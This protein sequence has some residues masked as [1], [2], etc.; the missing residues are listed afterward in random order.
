MAARGLLG[1]MTTFDQTTDAT[2]RRIAGALAFVVG[3]LQYA[4]LEGVAA[5]AWRSPPYDYVSN[6]ISD[7]GVADPQTYGGRVVDSPLAW[8]MNTG[9]VLEG[10]FFAVAAVLLSIA[11]SG[12]SR[13]LFVAFALLHAVGIVLVGF[14]D[15]TTAGG[16]HVGGAFASIVFGNL[17]ALVAGLAWRRLGLPGWFGVLS[18]ALPVVG[19]ASE[20]VLLAGIADPDLDGLFERGGVYSITAWQVV[21]GAVV[22]ARTLA[23]RRRSVRV[24]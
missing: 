18:V 15:E 20:V 8:V 9:F 11:F 6:Y 2:G 3:G 22:L 7:L 12:A 5:S 13:A 4:V 1:A 14:F 17:A 16:W 21:F 23:V 19:L 24:V 10:L